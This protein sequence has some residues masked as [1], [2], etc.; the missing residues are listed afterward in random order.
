MISSIVSKREHN[1]LEMIVKQWQKTIETENCTLPMGGL[2]QFVK[3]SVEFFS[4]TQ[5][6]E[7]ER[8]VPQSTPQYNR[9]FFVLSPI[10]FFSS[11][12]LF[13]AF[14]D[15][16][17]WCSYVSCTKL[18]IPWNWLMVA[19]WQTAFSNFALLY[20]WK[21]NRHTIMETNITKPVHRNPNSPLPSHV[22]LSNSERKKHVGSG[23]ARMNRFFPHS[24]AMPTSKSR[25]SRDAH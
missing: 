6:W 8:L 23:A 14:S 12:H 1:W 17:F 19:A 10:G 25:A 2:S 15:R 24:T 11:K 16:L 7:L 9:P 22:E 3:H 5:I 4:P 21:Q 18:S 13:G 20:R